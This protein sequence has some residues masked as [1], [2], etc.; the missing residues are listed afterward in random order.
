MTDALGKQSEREYDLLG[1]MTKLTQAKGTGLERLATVA[2]NAA[3]DMVGLTDFRGYRDATTVDA[4]HR[5]TAYKEAVGVTGERTTTTTFDGAGNVTSKVDPLNRTAT[6][7][8]VALNRETSRTLA[9]GTG[10][11]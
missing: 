9:S 2:Y 6:Y 8:Y 10:V 5:P 4:M 11:A 1:R 3:G 7:A